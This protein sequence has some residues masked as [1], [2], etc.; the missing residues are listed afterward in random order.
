MRRLD[1]NRGR[2]W[3]FGLALVA[4]AGGLRAEESGA[5][6]FEQQCAA[7]H[8]HDGKGRTPAGR[9]IGARDLTQSRLSEAEIARQVS[10][11][12]TDRTGKVKMPPFKDLLSA[13]EIQSVVAFARAFREGQK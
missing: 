13:S 2:T 7:C 6:I 4:C 5:A 3:V 9:K 12:S 11:G 1:R 8:G 10:E